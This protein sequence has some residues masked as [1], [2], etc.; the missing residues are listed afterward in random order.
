MRVRIPPIVF[1]LARDAPGNP[2]AQ[3]NA[4][5]DPQPRMAPPALFA[6]RAPEERSLGWRR[7]ACFSPRAALLWSSA[8]ARAVLLHVAPRGGV[9]P[10]VKTMRIAISLTEEQFNDL[11]FLVASAKERYAGKQIDVQRHFPDDDPKGCELLDYWKTC[12]SRATE[13]EA[14]LRA[15]HVEALRRSIKRGRHVR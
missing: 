12:E 14:L 15:K 5:S 6:F 9:F 4:I 13:A 7:R 11:T 2:P 3:L 1:F 10:G 8:P